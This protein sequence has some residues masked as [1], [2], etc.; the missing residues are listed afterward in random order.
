MQDPRENHFSSGGDLPAVVSDDTLP[1][2]AICDPR[3][4]K[5]LNSPASRSSAAV[6]IAA[7]NAIFSVPTFEVRRFTPSASNR[8]ANPANEPILFSRLPRRVRANGFPEAWSLIRTKTW[9]ELSYFNSAA[10]TMLD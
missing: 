1:T 4:S 5:A 3:S 10:G 8:S 9:I 6:L 2:P 7:A